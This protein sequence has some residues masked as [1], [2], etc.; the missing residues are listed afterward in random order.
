MWTK[1]VVAESKP[2]LGG[3]CGGTEEYHE[4]YHLG[5]STW[6]RKTGM[7][8]YPPE[9]GDRRCVNC[10]RSEAEGHCVH[11][12]THSSC[13]EVT[14]S[15]HLVGSGSVM[16][17]GQPPSNR[18]LSPVDIVSVV[19]RPACPGGVIPCSNDIT[20]QLSYLREC[21]W[22]CGLHRATVN[23]TITRAWW[24]TWSLASWIYVT[25]AWRT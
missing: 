6:E 2:F 16:N 9:R 1:A 8:D 21:F 13:V 17:A 15:F 4:I 25:S 10:I 19:C 12:L 14:A 11:C 23:I 5:Y 24:R 18:P 20:L 7:L 3:F 22:R